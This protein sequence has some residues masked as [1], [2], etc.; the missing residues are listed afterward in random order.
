MKKIKT[1]LVITL[2]STMAFAQNV[3]VRTA[4]PY[5]RAN[6][7]TTQ[8]TIQPSVKQEKR[9][10]EQKA[11]IAELRTEMRIALLPIDNKL[12]VNKAELRSLRQV[13]NPDMRKINKNI[14]EFGALIAQ[15][16][17][18]QTEYQVKVRAV[19]EPEQRVLYDMRSN[20]RAKQRR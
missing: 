3:N 14:D 4:P 7:R 15:K 11:K 18:I 2:I 12:E 8:P 10:P 19:L 1:L 17:K 20:T 9:T 13:D 5:A 16:R 6:P